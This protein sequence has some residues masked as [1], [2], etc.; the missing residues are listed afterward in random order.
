METFT[1]TKNAFCYVYDRELEDHETV[2]IKMPVVSP[3]KRG[4]NDIGWQSDGEVQ[5]YGTICRDPER[6]DTLW[7]EIEP[8]DEVNKTVAA[9]K[10]ENL[11]GACRLVIRAILN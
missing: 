1:N 5:L 6:P 2:I 3:N 11:G 4:V 7:Q 10:A 8:C 9:I